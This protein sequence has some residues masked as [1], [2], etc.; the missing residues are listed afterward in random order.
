MTKQ[1]ILDAVRNLVREHESETGGVLDNEANLFE[2]ICDATEA[3]VMDLMPFMPEQFLTSE[4]VTLVKDQ[5][6]YTL[7]NEYWMIYK[8]EKN[9]TDEAPQ[10]L[11]IIDPLQFQFY[12]NVGETEE[13]PTA[14]YFL[15]S[16]IYFVKTPSTAKTAY[17]RV[18]GVRPEATEMLVTGPQYMPRM[19]HRLIVYKAC[20]LVAISLEAETSKY[21]ALY[22]KRFASVIKLWSQKFISQPRY[23]QAGLNLRR[24]V[25]ARDSVFYDKDWS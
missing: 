10:E 12:T 22:T 9:V 17:A 18:W 20:E 24:T 16:T 23:V 5:A 7:T 15:G 25:D 1:D 19:A 6:N 4:T 21:E 14:V 8:V 11:E 3:V 13:S 2:Y